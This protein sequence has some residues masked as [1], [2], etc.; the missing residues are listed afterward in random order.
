MKNIFT[1]LTILLSLS[2]F[3][4]EPF[5]IDDCLQ[6]KG[7]VKKNAKIYADPDLSSHDRAFA[8]KFTVLY[9]FKHEGT[10]TPTKNEFYHVGKSQD[11][12]LGYIHEDNIVQWNHRLCVTFTDLVGSRSPALVYK[13]L[14]EAQQEDWD[15]NKKP[16]KKA[17]G[18][19]PTGK[20][21]EKYDML[22]PVLE[23]TS[24]DKKGGNKENMKAFKVAF[25]GET[26]K[27]AKPD[28]PVYKGKSNLDLMFLIDATGSMAGEIVG[29]KKVVKKLVNKIK[30]ME[31]TEVRIGISLY[32]DYGED[33]V[34]EKWQSLTTD[35]EKVLKRLSEVE[36][37]QGGD[38]EEAMYQGVLQT[39]NATNW[40]KGDN[41][42]VL[43]EIL[44]IGDAPGHEYGGDYRVDA[45]D[46]ITKASQERVRFIAMNV[47]SDAKLGKQLGDL[48]EGLRDGDQGLYIEASAVVGDMSDDYLNSLSSAITQEIERLKE[49]E[50]V[51]SGAKKLEDVTPLNRAIFLK[52][53]PSSGFDDIGIHFNEGWITEKNSK[54]LRQVEPFVFMTYGDLNKYKFFCQAAIAVAQSE[55]ADAGIIDLTTSKITALSGETY[56]PEMELD[57]HLRKT[58]CLPSSNSGILKYSLTEISRWSPLRKEKFILSIEDKVKLLDQIQRDNSQW[59]KPSGTDLKYTFVKLELMP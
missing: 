26:G 16:N 33:F 59:R 50:G 27:S 47:G 29:T 46:L 42:P 35:Y 54:G 40:S 49:L 19:E 5:K 9:M 48:S 17:I 56:D 6:L 43:R 32:K 37:S 18:Q 21:D 31:N 2:V 36:V 23:E 30:S 1:I 55:S 14:K 34:T 24:V 15:S 45:S 20:T 53:L 28:R 4:Q 8:E 38:T 44:I 58:L 22:L 12:P 51:R 10:S 39:I 7:I 57:E 25:L 3:G 11:T 13:T 41:S 52:N